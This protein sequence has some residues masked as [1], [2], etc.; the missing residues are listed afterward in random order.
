M[1]LKMP[2]TIRGLGIEP[3]EAQLK[4]MAEKCAAKFEGGV[5]TMKK[6]SAEDMEKIFRA[7][8]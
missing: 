1:R 6:L 4:E 2:V 3:T 5:G 8:M 7:A